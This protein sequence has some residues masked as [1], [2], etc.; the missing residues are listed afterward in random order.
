[1]F[2][3]EREREWEYDKLVER[4]KEFKLDPKQYDWYLDLRKYGSV[5]H[6]GFGLGIERT[7]KWILKLDHI[8]DVTP[9]PRVINRIY[10]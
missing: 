5:P 2:S 3:D 1:M 7:M 9:F 6:S 10:P 4:I 8:R